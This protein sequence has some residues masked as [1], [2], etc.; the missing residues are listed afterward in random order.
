L[1][2]DSEILDLL[3]ASLDINSQ[4]QDSES[5]QT[6]E[7]VEL[8]T[9]QHSTPEIQPNLQRPLETTTDNS[10]SATNESLNGAGN[11]QLMNG[12]HGLKNEPLT[13]VVLEEVEPATNQQPTPEIQ[14]DLQHPLETTTDNSNT[15][16]SESLNGAG[17]HQLMNG[18]QELKGEPLTG[19]ALAHR[20]NVSDTTISRR[21]SKPDFPKWTCSKDPEGIA[22]RYSKKSKLFVAS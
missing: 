16:T 7:E 15:V 20:L 13:G 9:N 1:I 3:S 17:N 11:H 5:L 22:W 2:E 14:P 4:E 21:K 12:S 18:S 10:N 6:L 8:A 19:V